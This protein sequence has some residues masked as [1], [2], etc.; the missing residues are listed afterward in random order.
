MAC[1]SAALVVAA[2]LLS[3]SAAQPTQRAPHLLFQAPPE[4]TGAARQ[5]ARIEPRPLA[6]IVA[7][8]GLSR[9]GPPIRVLLTQESSPLARRA[10]R[11]VAG[12]AIAHAD[13]V[14]LFPARTSGYPDDSLEVLLFHEVA[15][16]VIRRAAG[17]REVPRW[18]AEGLAMQAARQWGFSDRSQLL[19]ATLARPP[20][21]TRELE[22][23]FYRAPS[24]VR[25]AYALAAALVRDLQRRFGSETCARTLAGVADGMSFENAFLRAAGVP[26]DRAE[27]QFWRRHLRWYRWLPFLTSSAAL[28]MAVTSLVLLAYWRRRRRDAAIREAWEEEERGWHPDGL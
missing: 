19:L 25:G 3:S 7:L 28:W 10:P 4:L 16:I 5:L 9:P 26:L 13:T 2:A 20:T 6:R 18:F 17:G 15:H 23:E 8:V 27:S 24:R 1:P 11:W 21:S 14:V 22:T 12:Y